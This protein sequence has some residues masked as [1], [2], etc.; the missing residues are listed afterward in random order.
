M[1]EADVNEY[2]K[3]NSKNASF[4]HT[5]NPLVT[6]LLPTY[7]RADFLPLAIES[8]LRQSY[9]RLELIIIR[10]GGQAVAPIVQ[11][12]NDDRIRF[13]DRA[14]NRGKAASL[15]EAIGIARGSY[16]S[17]LDDD[18]VWYPNHLQVL[19]EAL[20][21]HPKFG[22]AYTDLYK[23]HYRSLPGSRRLVL[24]K[25]IEISRD[26][27]RLLMLQFNHVLHVSLMHRRD[28]LNKAGLYNENLNVLIDW[29]LTRRLCFYTDFLHVPVVTGEYYAAIENSDRVSI[30]RRKNVNDYVRN[31]LTIRSSRPPK[32]WPYIQDV[33]VV[34]LHDKADDALMQ[35]LRLLWGHSFYPHQVY[36]PLTSQEFQK[37]ESGF[38][39]LVHV[40]T[41]QAC[42][43]NHRLDRVLEVCE[44]DYVAII[45]T[46]LTVAS[47]EACFIERSLN[48]LL[49]LSQENCAFEIVESDSDHWGAIFRMS[50]LQQARKRFPDKEI[51]WAAQASGIDIRKPREAEYPFQF[52]NL[53]TAVTDLQQDGQWIRAERVMEYMSEH[54]GNTDWMQTLRANALYW[55]GRIEEASLIA[56]QLNQVR[57]TVAC[58]LIEAR[59]NKKSGQFQKAAALFRRAQDILDGNHIGLLKSSN[60]HVFQTHY[61]DKGCV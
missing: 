27:D 31:V 44:G 11:S 5:A 3:V 61:S 10:D 42:D 52:D 9:Q 34:I 28:L 39:N 58:L 19:L 41:P 25:N 43:P 54:Y 12:Y 21:Q 23:A 17:Y 45:P 47:D 55:A 4:D 57:P 38:P 2:L 56:H 15:N 26:F 14:E 18:D 7:N 24:A 33:S 60:N 20:Q 37:V 53:L 13:I 16:I 46:G 6:V 48:P 22:L 40:D 59:C 32:P 35:T 30:Q 29:D 8:V 36:L 49:M 50:Q 1:T 51:R